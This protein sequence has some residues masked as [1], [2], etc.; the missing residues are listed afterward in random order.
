MNI[1]TTFQ[2]TAVASSILVALGAA[3]IAP[4]MASGGGREV[5]RS[6]N[7]S[8]ST[9]WKLKAK[10]DDGR[11]Q[12]EAEIDSNVNGQVWTWRILH[13]GGVSA[14]GRATTQAPSGSFEVRRLLV[15]TAGTDNIGIRSTNTVTG[16]TCA[17]NLRF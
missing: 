5:D 8:A 16:E 14:K 2:R 7:C 13:N 12:V 11:I 9:D 4:A 6:G 10:S 3:T 1:T 15:N 17:G